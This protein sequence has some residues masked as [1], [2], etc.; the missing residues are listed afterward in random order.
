MITPHL[1]Q[2]LCHKSPDGILRQLLRW[3]EHFAGIHQVYPLAA[4]RHTNKRNLYL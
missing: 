2:Y 1:R 3:T 4:T